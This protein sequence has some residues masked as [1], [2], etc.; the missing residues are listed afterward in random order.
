MSS[1]PDDNPGLLFDD[2]IKALRARNITTFTD[3]VD[4]ASMTSKI[5]FY[6]VAVPIAVITL[7][8][9]CNLL[10]CAIF[11]PLYLAYVA[12]HEPILLGIDAPRSDSDGLR[13]TFEDDRSRLEHMLRQRA[14]A[15]ERL[16]Q[17]FESM[18]RATRE[19][20]FCKWFNQWNNGQFRRREQGRNDDDM[21]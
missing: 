11:L 21:L 7:Q 8:L 20:R 16:A 3:V 14:A 17:R 6:A 10:S 1:L 4:D 18:W 15:G 5:L 13:P 2:A 19:T 12:K 9:L